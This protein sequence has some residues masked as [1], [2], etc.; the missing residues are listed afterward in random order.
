MLSCCTGILGRS[1]NCEEAGFRIRITGLA[2]VGDFK[3]ETL[4]GLLPYAELRKA[5]VYDY[6]PREGHARGR[7][8]VS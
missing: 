4:T 7:R 2:S 6:R 5:R 1:S 8:S 3:S